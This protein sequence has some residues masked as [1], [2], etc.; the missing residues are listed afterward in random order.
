MIGELRFAASCLTDVSPSGKNE[1]ARWKFI[2]LS[3]Y[4]NEKIHFEEKGKFVSVD[5]KQKETTVRQGGV[6]LRSFSKQKTLFKKVK[7]KLS[8]FY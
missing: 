1:M 8:E 5:Q 2:L 7:R 6:A 3:R 4:R